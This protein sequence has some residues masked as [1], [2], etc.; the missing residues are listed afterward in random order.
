MGLVTYLRSPLPSRH[1]SRSIKELGSY[2]C[3]FILVED[4]IVAFGC[5]FLDCG[6]RRND[7]RKSVRIFVM[8][9]KAGIQGCFQKCKIST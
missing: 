1:P 7:G 4:Q 2:A 5:G 6:V 9:A 3:G 8:P